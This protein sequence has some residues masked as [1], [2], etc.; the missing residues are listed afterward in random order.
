MYMFGG[1][2]VEHKYRDFWIY[3][4]VLE[5]WIEVAISTPFPCVDTN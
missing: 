4:L 3:D 1:A 2:M 5:E